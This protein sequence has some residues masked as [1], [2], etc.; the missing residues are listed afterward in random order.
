[1]TKSASMISRED[2]SSE[3]DDKILAASFLQT[4]TL[5][6]RETEVLML[7]YNIDGKYCQLINPQFRE[8]ASF[9]G[10]APSRAQQ[11]ENKGIHKIKS[12]YSI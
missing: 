6:K 8:I 9:L 4:E 3:I 11:L 5:T 7:R 1:L 2:F 10:I 12:Y